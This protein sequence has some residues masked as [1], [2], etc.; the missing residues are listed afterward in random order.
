MFC[1]R[2]GGGRRRRDAVSSFIYLVV[3]LWVQDSGFRVPPRVRGGALWKGEEEKEEKE[4][5]D[6]KDEEDEEEEEED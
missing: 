1:C 3:F 5:E 4:E 2:S 6:E